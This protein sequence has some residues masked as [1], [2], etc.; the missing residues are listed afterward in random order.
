MKGLKLILFS[1]AVISLTNGCKKYDEGPSISLTSK[2][3]RLA[4]SWKFEDIIFNGENNLTKSSLIEN[5]YVNIVEFKKDNTF[6]FK[7]DEGMLAEGIWSFNK[8]KTVIELSYT[9]TFPDNSTCCM[10][11]IK[12]EKT[13]FWFSDD[14]NGAETEFRCLPNE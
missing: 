2:K 12:L 3:A 4:N 11:I 5:S 8:N 1:F 10:K 6:I 7:L 9:S 14:G 13:E